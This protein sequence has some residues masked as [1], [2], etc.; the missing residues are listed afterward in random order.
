MNIIL[1]TFIIPKVQKLW[2]NIFHLSDHL[3]WPILWKSDTKNYFMDP[4]YKQFI[5]KLKHRILPTKDNLFKIG[6]VTDLMCPFCKTE[7]ESHGHL[8]IYCIETIEAWVYV[9]NMLRHYTANR[10]FYLNDANVILRL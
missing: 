10:C 5:Y 9:E 4:D 8:F 1:R 3:E 7:A 2:E 6:K